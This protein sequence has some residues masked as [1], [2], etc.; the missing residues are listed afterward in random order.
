MPTSD[1]NLAF[2]FYA[3]NPARCALQCQYALE[4]ASAPQ[5]VQIYD[6]RACALSWEGLSTDT[7]RCII[8]CAIFHYDSPVRLTFDVDTIREGLLEAMLRVQ[9][10]PLPAVLEDAVRFVRCEPPEGVCLEGSSRLYFNRRA[11]P[12]TAYGVTPSPVLAD[13]SPSQVA[14]LPWVAEA[15]EA[16]WRAFFDPSAPIR[17]SLPW[18]ELF[19]MIQDRFGRMIHVGHFHALRGF[20]LDEDRMG[21]VLP[22]DNH[23]ALKWSLGHLLYDPRNSQCSWISKHDGII[24]LPTYAPRTFEWTTG[25]YTPGIFSTTLRP[26]IRLTMLSG[27]LP[28]PSLRLGSPSPPPISR[29]HAVRRCLLMNSRSPAASLTP[30]LG[31]DDPSDGETLHSESEACDEDGTEESDDLDGFIDDSDL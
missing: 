25:T 28:R 29:R 14:T 10:D 4:D 15:R 26:N 18:Q 27:V 16:L 2:P 11:L 20:P 17:L 8:L 13:L 9:A 6:G 21:R 31:P 19:E 1:L 23:A 30:P 12:C 7:M 22:T 24:P 5:V 3:A